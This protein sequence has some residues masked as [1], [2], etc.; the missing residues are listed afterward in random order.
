VILST[1][2]PGPGLCSERF[3]AVLY[4]KVHAG[5]CKRLPSEGIGWTGPVNSI[6]NSGVMQGAEMIPKY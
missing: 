4:F 6:V 2:R 1:A 5:T 3:L